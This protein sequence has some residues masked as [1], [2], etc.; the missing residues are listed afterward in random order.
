MRQVGVM[1]KLEIEESLQT[2]CESALKRKLRHSMVML[3]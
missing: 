1:H 3:V 2:V